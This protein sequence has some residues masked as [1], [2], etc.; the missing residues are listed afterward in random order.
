MTHDSGCD[1]GEATVPI[2]QICDPQNYHKWQD[3]IIPQT[4]TLS[5]ITHSYDSYHMTHII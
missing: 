4:S 1:P 2:D 3:C 5:G